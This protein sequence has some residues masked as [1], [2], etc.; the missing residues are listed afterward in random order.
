MHEGEIIGSVADGGQIASIAVVN[1]RMLGR[2]QGGEVVNDSGARV[3]G[4]NDAGEVT[5][6]NGAVI[7]VV[8]TNVALGSDGN[9][10]R[11]ELRQQRR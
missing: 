3:A 8:L 11:P 1:C 9:W 10:I 4:V 5:D 6:D 2:V 7:G